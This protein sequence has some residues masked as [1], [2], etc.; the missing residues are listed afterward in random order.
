PLKPNGYR[1]KVGVPDAAQ[2]AIQADV[3]TAGVSVGK[4]VQKD[5]YPGPGNRTVATIELDRR[6]APLNRDAHA[7]LRQKTLLGETYLEL[8]PGTKAA[9]T[10]PED[11]FLGN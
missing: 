6:F 1:F 3:R 2:L 10:V 8:T 7:I 11:H 9:G 5:L 4:V